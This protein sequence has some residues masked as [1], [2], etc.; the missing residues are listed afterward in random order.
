MKHT[1]FTMKANAADDSADISLHDEIGFWGVTAADFIKE[2]KSLAAKNINLSINSP[3]GSVF[4]GL[5]IY[6]ALKFSGKQINVMVLGI[7]ASAASIVAMAGTKISMPSN[8]FMMI[9][10]PMGV[11]MGGAEEMRGMAEILD[12]ITASAVGIYTLRTGQS[13]EDITAMLNAETYLTA[14]EAKD[15]GFAEEVLDEVKVTA[16]FDVDAL[17]AAVKTAY[18]TAQKVP[19][20]SLDT[21]T[22]EASAKA[23]GFEHFAARWALD[24][25][26][27][28][29]AELDSI[30]VLAKETKAL[31]MLCKRPEAIDLF[32]EAKTPLTEVRAKLQDSLASKDERESI[33]TTLKITNPQNPQAPKQPTAVI[34][35]AYI[36]SVYAKRNRS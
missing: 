14:A 8:T 1:W 25:A 5:A 20:K 23:A 10:N 6:N 16:S 15:K 7:A 4:D 3:G 17:P 30:I 13:A 22:I 36:A 19:V 29:K 26:I 18:M 34:D 24:P 33:D 28:N 12:K 11:A 9:H 27:T 31:C 35:D 2:F 32:V 21:D